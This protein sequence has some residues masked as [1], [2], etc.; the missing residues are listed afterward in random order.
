MPPA[1][2]PITLLT[3]ADCPTTEIL[4]RRLH[5][6]MTALGWKPLYRVVD[7]ATLPPLDRRLAYPVPTLLWRGEDLFGLAERPAPYPPAT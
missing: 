4:R 6:A 1:A 3:C 7:G 5:E 2:V